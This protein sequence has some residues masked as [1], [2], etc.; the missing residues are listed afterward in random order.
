MPNKT[1]VLTNLKSLISAG[2]VAPNEVMKLFSATDSNEETSVGKLLSLQ[3]I[4]YFVGSLIVI[5][6]LGI[7]I[8][9]FWND[10]PQMVKV[11]FALSLSGLTYA[12]GY[13]LYLRSQH[14]KIFSYISFILSALLLPLGIGTFLNLAGLPATEYLG[15][16]IT[17]VLSG[18]VFYLSYRYLSLDLFAAFAIAAVSESFFALT[19]LLVIEPTDTFYFY[20]FLLL[21]FSYLAG[22]YHL[23]RQRGR[24]NYLVKLLYFFGA[25]LALGGA[26]GLSLYSTLWLVLYPFV[27]V[28]AF[29]TSVHLEDK[30]ILVLATVFTF[31]EIARITE[32][33]FSESLGWPIALM[34][35]GFAIIFVG[36]TS[37]RLNKEYI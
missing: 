15:L 30:L 34:I 14:E 5:L 10:W 20:R 11:V 13:F 29:Y 21:G 25:G 31:M 23:Q 18:M 6:G 28:G 9:Q 16:L 7:F 4:F 22:G 1:Q 8:G 12:A 33:Y 37:F 3:N 26:F 35:A 2:E 17:S 19:N 36:Y 27:L 32:K 24:K